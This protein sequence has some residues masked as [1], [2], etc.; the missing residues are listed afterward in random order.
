MKA[1]KGELNAYQHLTPLAKARV[2]PIFEIPTEKWEEKESQRI[3]FA[4]K[5][6]NQICKTV[7]Y[8]NTKDIAFD[9][10]FWNSS[11]QTLENGEHIFSYMY[12]HLTTKG[13]SVIPIIGY[14]RWHNVTDPSYQVAIKSI[15][16]SKAPYF[17][18]RLDGEALEHLHEPFF[19]EEQLS[20]IL[21]GLKINIDRCLILVD[22][23]NLVGKNIVDT[24]NEISKKVSIISE[25]NPL[26]IAISGNSI[27]KS[28]NKIVT[29]HDSTSLI[30][31]SE[32]II[33]KMVREKN[34]NNSIIYSDYG[35]IAPD[36]NEQN[37]GNNNTN[38]GKIRYTIDRQ[39]F[40]VRGHPFGQDDGKHIQMHNLA[41]I[42][43]DSI[44]F[45]NFSWGDTKIKACSEHQLLGNQT[46]WISFEL[47]HHITYILEEVVIPSFTQ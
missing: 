16:F 22:Q 7:H 35:I 33:W 43:V 39:L 34:N 3:D 25:L 47:N 46:Q 26:A 44:Y 41:K 42:V 23:H 9:Y 30:T 5:K 6:I 27:P 1:K 2:L 31:R 11:Y 15:D 14:D 37:G 24:S 29:D 8:E 18:I 38:N 32:E 17:I 12:G 36:G 19:F 40:V 28:I 10:S 13:Y 20:E 45:E 21:S 4:D